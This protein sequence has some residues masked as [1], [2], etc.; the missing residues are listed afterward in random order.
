MFLRNLWKK[1]NVHLEIPPLPPEYQC[2]SGSVFKDFIFDSKVGNETALLLLEDPE[3]AKKLGSLKP[4]NLYSVPGMVRTS[5]GIIAYIIWSV[6]SRH[7]HVVDYE[8]PLNPFNMDTIRLLS[9]VAQ[10][11]HLKVLIVD[12]YNSR[13]EGFYEFKNNFRMDDFVSGISRAIG[14]E[15][16]ADFK[17]T[18]AAMR[19]EFTVEMLKGNES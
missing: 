19:N 16:V 7:G 6:S 4:F 11:S 1:G 18:Q 14:N 5:A 17:A 13:V 3:F 10:Q 15:P 8:H 9:N 2:V 12:S